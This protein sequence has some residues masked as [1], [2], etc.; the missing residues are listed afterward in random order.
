MPI[1]AS[2]F[3]LVTVERFT[4]CW[5]ETFAATTHVTDSAPGGGK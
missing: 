1:T 2:E 5:L 4:M 3:T